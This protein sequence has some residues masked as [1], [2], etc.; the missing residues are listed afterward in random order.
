MSTEIDLE[1]YAELI[2]EKI[3]GSGRMAVAILKWDAER[4]IAFYQDEYLDCETEE[5]GSADELPDLPTQHSKYDP[6]FNT[7]NRSA[8]KR[9]PG[10]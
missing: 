8:L 4:V 6:P 1:A 5:T 7:S 3:C 2:R 10:T 9:Q